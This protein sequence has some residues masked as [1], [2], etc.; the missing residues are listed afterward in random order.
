MDGIG[1]VNL[2]HSD[3]QKFYPIDFRLYAPD[4]DGKTKNNHLLEMLHGA[5]RLRVR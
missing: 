4:Q 3:G 5:K 1:I 2:I